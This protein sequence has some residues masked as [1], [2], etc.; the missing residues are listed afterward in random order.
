MRK[1]YQGYHT[2]VGV[3][4][5]HLQRVSNE[6]AALTKTAVAPEITELI[7]ASSVL[8]LAPLSSLQMRESFPADNGN[9]T[10]DHDQDGDLQG[11]I[12]GCSPAEANPDGH[13]STTDAAA[14]DHGVCSG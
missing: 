12:I 7:E 2:H 6:L 11:A 10:S 3:L 8:P 4:K 13:V 5:T 14:S 9:D 1:A